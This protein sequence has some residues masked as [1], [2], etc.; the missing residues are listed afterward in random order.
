LDSQQIT[1]IVSVFGAVVAFAG[2]MRQSRRDMNEQLDGVKTELGQ[3]IDGVKTELGQ[4][5]DGVETKLERQHGAI[6]ADMSLM[7]MDLERQIDR[8][9]N[10]LE[11]QI[12]GV[13]SNVTKIYSRLNDLE[14][15]S[16]DLARLL[17]PTPGAQV[18]S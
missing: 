8:V 18:A 3:R 16:Y 4:R 1:T 12:G 6:R 17:P 14:R 5:I 15:R 2:L 13:D 7:K 11:R 9:C 10:D